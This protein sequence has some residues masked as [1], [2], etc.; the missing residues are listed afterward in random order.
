MMKIDDQLFNYAIQE[1]LFYFKQR[2]VKD[3]QTA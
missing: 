3:V 1:T 2:I